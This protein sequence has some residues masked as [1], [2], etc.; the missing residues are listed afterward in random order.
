MQVVDHG[1]HTWYLLQDADALLLE[2]R[3]SDSA[4]DYSWLIELTADERVALAAGG[5][6]YV[7]KLAEA[8]HM[9]TP[10]RHDSRSPYKHRDV[11]ATRGDQVTAAI[12]AW[13]K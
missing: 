1:P 3:C 5:H 2:A 9:S 4:A 12:K 13:L 7:D 10:G 6:G 8:I 11:S